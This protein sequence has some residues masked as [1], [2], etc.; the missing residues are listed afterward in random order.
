GAVRDG[1][2]ADADRLVAAHALMIA[3][4]AGARVDCLLLPYLSATPMRPIPLTHIARV[5]SHASALPALPE[6][7]RAGESGY[8]RGDPVPFLRLI[9]AYFVR[10]IKRSRI[11]WR[12]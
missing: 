8:A 11:L 7:D 10:K 5:R 12:R 2:D 4:R 3:K 1:D 9:T 6:S